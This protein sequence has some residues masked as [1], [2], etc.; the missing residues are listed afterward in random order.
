M[1][2]TQGQQ[3]LLNT[4][5]GADMEKKAHEIVEMEKVA[6]EC[7]TYGYELAMQ[8]IAEMEEEAAK[9]KEEDKKEEKEEEKT[10]S[11]MGQ[12]ILDSYWGTLM[13]K[14]AEFYGNPDI[15][16][17]KLAEGVAPGMLDKLKGALGYLHPKNIIPE[18]KAMVAKGKTIGEIAGHA[19]KLA[20]PV[21][22]LGGAGYG[23]YRGG[24]AIY[25]KMKKKPE[26]PQY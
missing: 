12:I 11:A 19:G 21:A 3:R 8:K 23:G 16:I 2:L 14:G 24:K 10:A 26:E 6:S 18:A 22:A 4:D 7:I 25:N 15:Y 13:E 5:F 20:L 17:D 9:E 1:N